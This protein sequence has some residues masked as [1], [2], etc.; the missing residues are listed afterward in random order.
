MPNTKTLA[1]IIR[2]IQALTNTKQPTPE[3]IEELDF[4]ISLKDTLNQI[5]VPGEI[6]NLMPISFTTCPLEKA[7]ELAN[8]IGLKV[9]KGGSGT[10]YASWSKGLVD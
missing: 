4:Y 8:S 9:V 3:E 1:E 10:I 5:F 2:R 7:K 6:S